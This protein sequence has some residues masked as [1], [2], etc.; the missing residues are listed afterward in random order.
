M[1]K[2]TA[3]LI[4]HTITIL[5]ASACAPV[6]SGP[7][8]TPTLTVPPPPTSSPI[9][10][11]PTAAPHPSSTPQPTV[12]PTPACFVTAYTP[13]AFLPGSSRILSWAS[14]SVQVFDLSSLQEV[15]LLTAPANL[16]AVALSP[17]EGTLA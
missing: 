8:A 16:V 12:S 17:D 4:L 2:T 5:L 3:F 7:A 9:P 10:P 15:D 1:H 13:V 6:S 14:A 11:S